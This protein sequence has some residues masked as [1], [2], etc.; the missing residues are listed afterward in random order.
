[1]NLE[2]FVK[3][4]NVKFC[5][6]LISQEYLHTVEAILG[7][8]FGPELKTFVL[9]YGYLFYEGILIFGINT[10]QLLDSEMVKLTMFIHERYPQTKGLIAV[11][12]QGEDYYCLVN[13]KDEVFDFDTESEKLTSRSIKLFDYILMRFTLAEE[14]G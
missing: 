4:K 10:V 7:V 13:D 11:E 5:E 8:S 1:M 3:E 6:H 2:E 9:E 14:S 12:D